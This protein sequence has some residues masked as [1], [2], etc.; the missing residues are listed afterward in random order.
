MSEFDPYLKW[1][2]IRDAAR[3]INHYRL[4]GL[5]MFENDPD[6]ISMAAD[7]QMTHIRTY[8]NGPNGDLSQQ[9]LNELARARRCLLIPEKKAEYDEQIR[10]ELRRPISPAR[11]PSSGQLAPPIAVPPLA[12]PTARRA[13]SE[14][15]EVVQPSLIESNAGSKI[16]I[17]T[18]GNVR[19]TSRRRERKQLLWTLFGWATGGLAAVGIGAWLIGSGL[20]PNTNPDA[21]PGNDPTVASGLPQGTSGGVTASDDPPR[22]PTA[23]P[24]KQLRRPPLNNRSPNRSPNRPDPNRPESKQPEPGRRQP[25][26]PAT[27]TNQI[28][29]ATARR[30]AAEAAQ[31]RKTLATYPRPGT[32][33]LA[34]LKQVDESTAQDK[35]LRFEASNRFGGTRE[36]T[37]KDN[38]GALLIGLA[39]TPREDQSIRSIQPI[40][41]SSRRKAYLGPVVGAMNQSSQLNLARQFTIAKPGYAVGELRMSML[42]PIKCL[43]IKFMRITRTGLDRHDSYWSDWIGVETEPVK[44]VA[45]ERG[46]PVVGF[47]SRFDPRDGIATLGLV[48][49]DASISDS[50]GA[51]DVASNTP[52]RPGPLNPGPLN[53]ATV[54]PGSSKSPVPG[55]RDR[56]QAKDSVESDF[57]DSILGIRNVRDLRD[58]SKQLVRS[59]KTGSDD[60]AI[61]YAKFEK[62]RE[63][64]VFFGDAM[65]AIDALRAI[66]EKFEIEFWEE[67]L[68]TIEDAELKANTNTQT[69]FKR[70]MDQLIDEAIDAQHFG[71][72]GKLIANASLMAKRARDVAAQDKY[73]TLRKQV[74]EMDRLVEQSNKAREVLAGNPD[75]PEAN[76]QQGDYL[77][78]IAEDVDA[79]F[80]CWQKSGLKSLQDLVSQEKATDHKDGAQLVTLADAW[81]DVGDENR[82]ER[83]RKCLQRAHNHYRA[84]L[85][86]LRG[87]ERKSVQ[88]KIKELDQILN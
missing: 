77:F 4:L 33:V 59:G 72:A 51:A 75:D 8:Q 48:G 60:D 16:G 55:K 64:G 79:A 46:L 9:I 38:R 21:D 36:I 39:T 53:P 88:S 71:P 47:H 49:A 87:L 63:L 26:R 18:D 40:F 73:K 28:D 27:A 45:N 80:A 69:D 86:L 50:R 65:T 1:L 15:V 56:Q 3:P 37:V 61:Q 13:N 19:K 34:L 41:L 23:Q 14:D 82:S 43:R 74:V 66:D 44:T 57:R 67:V 2:G 81:K 42:D 31:H 32:D 58:V 11:R 30:L 5:D 68:D 52:L 62:A 17:T 12:E 20:L 29:A 76:L 70:T 35:I 22:E 6:V 7:R 25:N 24:G 54:P 85:A 78:V 84:A 83:D 10:D